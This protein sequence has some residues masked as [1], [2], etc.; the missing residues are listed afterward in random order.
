[1]TTYTAVGLLFA[2]TFTKSM[3]AN[4]PAVVRRATTVAFGMVNVQLIL[5][6][7]TLITLVPVPLAAAHQ[8]GSV[9]L[10][11]TMMHVLLSLRRPGLA[12]RAWRNVLS[13][14]PKA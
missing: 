1:M 11:S 8:A 10:L 4:L 13:T 7:F 5:G 14:Q 3:K 9:L 2:Q 6:I 12:A